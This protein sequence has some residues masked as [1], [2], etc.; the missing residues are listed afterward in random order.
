MVESL[1][2]S[3][4]AAALKG[5]VE[6][7]GPEGLAAA[8]V[9]G[10]VESLPVVPLA[11]APPDED[12]GRPAAEVKGMVGSAAAGAAEGLMTGGAGWPMTTGGVLAGPLE[13]GVEWFVA[14]GGV[15]TG[16]LDGGTV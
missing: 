1:A 5:M 16:P 3:P 13:G 11:P 10:I 12:A 6:S 8:D 2:A 15:L 7:L 14:A 9:K 4:A